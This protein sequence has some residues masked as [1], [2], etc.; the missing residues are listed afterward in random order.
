MLDCLSNTNNNQDNSSTYD[1]DSGVPPGAAQRRD[2]DVAAWKRGAD[3]E[4]LPSVVFAVVAVVAGGE[5]RDLWEREAAASDSCGR[6]LEDCGV[7]E[8]V[9][10]DG[11]IVRLLKRPGVKESL[12]RE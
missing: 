4:G 10:D 8:I 7:G 5:A 6:P 9:A 12:G 2:G 3:D 11:G 1:Y